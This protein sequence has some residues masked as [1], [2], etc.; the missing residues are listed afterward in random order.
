MNSLSQPAN[1]SA[2]FWAGVEAVKLAML[3]MGAW[4]LVTGVAMVQAGLSPAQAIG[5]NVL[6]YAG[7]AQLAALPLLVAGTPAWV[8]LLT[9]LVIN[10]RFLI[11][12]TNLLATF[13]Q[14]PRWQRFALGSINTDL[15]CAVYVAHVEAFPQ[16][17][18]PQYFYL[19]AATTIWVTWQI[20]STLGILLASTLPRD[21]VLEFAGTLALIPI[22]LPFLQGRVGWSCGLLAVV[23]ALALHALPLKLGLLLAVCTGAA[24]AY[25]LG[26]SAYLP[27]TKEEAKRERG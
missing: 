22:T 2:S 5:M 14:L 26:P 27:T 25:V 8:I 6:V 23:I 17:R 24:L 12:S 13:K 9:T 4:G 10:V 11:Y 19:G 20:S 1:R 7:A 16:A 18:W 21:G 3:A 15:G